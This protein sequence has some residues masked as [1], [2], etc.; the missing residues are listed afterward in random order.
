MNRLSG[1]SS[2]AVLWLVFTCNYSIAGW[3]DDIRLT[4]SGTEY[5]PHVVARNDAIHVVWPH[6]THYIAYLRSID[7][8]NTWDSLVNLSEDGHSA[9][10]PDISIGENGLFV[11]WLDRDILG[12][13]AYTMSPEGSQWTAPV[14]LPTDH[15]DDIFMPA[16]AVK[17]DSIFIAYFSYE[18]DSTGR[19][20]I[21]FFSS[22]DYGQTWNDEVTVGHPY[23]TQQDY[24]LS[25]CGSSLLIAKSGFVDSL[26]SG[27]HVV[28]YRSDDG[29]RTWSG[30]IWISPE[31]WYSAQSPCVACNEETGQIAV[32]YMD[33][34]NQEYAFFGDIFIAIS[35]DGGQ[36]WPR[37]VRAT[38]YP[39]A[40]APSV[41]F[42]GDTLVTCW[43][44]R[45]FGNPDGTEIFFNRSDDVGITWT[46]DYRLTDNLYA[47]SEPW[48]SF[49][50]SKVHVIW[51]EE[52][53]NHNPD[54]F[55]KR[56]T[57]GGT[58]ITGSQIPLR[59]YIN[60]SVY[61]N[62]FNSSLSILVVA[63]E[64]GSIQIYDILG[65]EVCELGYDKGLNVINWQ[66][67]NDDGAPLTSGVYFIKMKNDGLSS[68]V[69]RIIYLK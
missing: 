66:A 47:S 29:G 62:P 67:R 31:Q 14:Y 24:L 18:V 4:Y 49:D 37:E 26:H 69:R 2:L 60:L 51:R 16:S 43:S 3:S 23:S 12:R 34:R 15:I 7:G 63:P 8:G 30:L 58:S 28:G 36:T 39:T 55:Y 19:K 53:V 44:D 41:D 64:S 45:R 52:D 40:T 9:Q 25:Y 21:R 38:Q 6:D 68:H 50:N 46:G 17:G 57:P 33:Y 54:L 20:P 32:G 61:P 5:H 35:D 56:F 13:I 42:T 65:R 11:S 10:Y 22:Y 27:Y 1:I 59:N 48:L